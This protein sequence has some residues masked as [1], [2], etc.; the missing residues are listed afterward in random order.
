MFYDFGCFGR[1]LTTGQLKS[2]PQESENETIWPMFP[3]AFGIDIERSH[4]PDM[5]PRDPID[6]PD[7]HST[8]L[9]TSDTVPMAQESAPMLLLSMFTRLFRNDFELW[10]MSWIVCVDPAKSVDFHSTCPGEHRGTHARRRKKSILV[11]SQGRSVSSN[12][13]LILARMNNDR[14][15]DRL[16]VLIFFF[17][18]AIAISLILNLVS[19]KQNK[20]IFINLS[21]EGFRAGL[22]RS[23]FLAGWRFMRHPM[24][25]EVPCGHLGSLLGP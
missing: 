12:F 4:G 3:E 23:D 20:N 21:S 13:K 2:I 9:S 8:P 25:T 7:G 11:D 19:K 16:C 10:W 1:L 17:Q 24:L 18:I 15:A 6:S 5:M 22:R 14:W